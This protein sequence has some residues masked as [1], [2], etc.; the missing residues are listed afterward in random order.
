M[1]LAANAAHLAETSAHVHESECGFCGESKRSSVQVLP[2]SR[3]VSPQ[4]AKHNRGSNSGAGV[5]TIKL[6]DA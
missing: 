4:M 5:L 2:A 6:I 3:T 1:L